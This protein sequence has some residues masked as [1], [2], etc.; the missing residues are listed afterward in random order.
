MPE[1]LNG[2][3]AR[4]SARTRARAWARGTAGVP[5]FPASAPGHPGPE[6]E[7]CLLAR[8][9][10]PNAAGASS[11]QAPSSVPAA[12]EFSSGAVERTG[13]LPLPTATDPAARPRPPVATF[14]RRA[15][16]A[17]PSPARYRA[18]GRGGGIPWTV[19]DCR[20][21]NLVPQRHGEERPATRSPQAQEM[22][23]FPDT[24][25]RNKND[26]KN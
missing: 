22:L 6:H 13:P 2:I 15:Y 26:L 1:F 9:S 10:P 23:P 4:P 3:G 8:V 16:E 20:R 7:L 14:R 11:P 18:G 12:G 17:S 21:M 5:S 19:D 24:E 25:G